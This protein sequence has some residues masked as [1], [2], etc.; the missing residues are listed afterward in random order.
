MEYFNTTFVGNID[1]TLFTLA[2]RAEQFRN[3]MSTSIDP[4]RP[5]LIDI[6]VLHT[7]FL[8]RILQGRP[9]FAAFLQRI[10]DDPLDPTKPLQF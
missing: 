8:K 7:I 6:N 4:T 3:D 1:S 5:N 9:E 2:T 10:I